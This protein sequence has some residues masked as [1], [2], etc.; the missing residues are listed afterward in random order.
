MDELFDDDSDI[1]SPKSFTSVPDHTVGD[2]ES[3]ED[4]VQMVNVESTDG[5]DE[6][7]QEEDDLDA[8]LRKIRAQTGRGTDQPASPCAIYIARNNTAGIM[9]GNEGGGR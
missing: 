9:R 7:E 6:S 4:D 5:G 3:T 1:S 8:D 2:G